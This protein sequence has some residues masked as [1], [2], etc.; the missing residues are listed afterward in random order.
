MIEEILMD[1]GVDALA[2][3]VDGT[4]CGALNGHPPEAPASL[5]QRSYGGKSKMHDS[6][7]RPIASGPLIMMMI[8][9]HK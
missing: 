4:A 8:P 1:A 3:H 9:P 7:R 5:L 2:G 6:R